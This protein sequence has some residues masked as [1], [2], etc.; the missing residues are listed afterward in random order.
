MTGSRSRSSAR[1]QTAQRQSAQHQTGSRQTGQHE[2]GPHEAWGDQ[3][4]LPDSVGLA[5]WAAT[6][7]ALGLTGIGAFVDLERVN[8][9]GIVFQLC[10]FLGCLLAVVVVRRKGLF[11]PMVAPPLI[12]AVAV[13][14][15]VL[16]VSSRHP[17]GGMIATALAVGT[18]LITDFPTMA[19]TTGI[20]V[21][22]GT[23]RLII[24]RQPSSRHDG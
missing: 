18:P 11:G 24:Q 7:C 1:R 4:L 20:T 6:L 9:L 12:L 15:T 2:A 21:A 19:I 22:I 10:Y 5:W 17:S 14:G 13:P 23:L 3:A 16:A 8:H